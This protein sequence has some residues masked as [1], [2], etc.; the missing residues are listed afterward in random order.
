MILITGGAGFI[1]SNFIYCWQQHC[2][3]EI[4]NIDCLTYAG[5]LYN[6]Q[7]VD[8]NHIFINADIN[9]Y[10]DIKNIIDKFKPR[11]V[12]HFAAESHVD[13][14]ITNPQ[15]FINTNVLGTFNLLHASLQYY[16]QLD[17]SKKSTFKFI[18]ISTDEVYGSL[19]KEDNA[20]TE[21]TNYAPNSP[22]SASKAASDHIARS[23]FHTYGLPCI[24]THCSNNY[25]PY[26]FPEKLIPLVISNALNGKALPIYGDGLNIRDWLHVSDHCQ[27]LIT[28]LNNGQNGEVYNIGGCNEKT[29]LEVVN[30]ICNILDGLQ[31]KTDGLSYKQQITFVQDRL[32]HDRRYAIDNTKI[33]QELNWQ[34][35]Y[36]FEQGIKN[37]VD[38]YLNNQ[39][40]LKKIISGEYKELKSLEK[41]NVNI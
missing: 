38:W 3:E 35:Q 33:Q 27:A 11:A 2:T 6:L 15:S 21:Q 28:I 25:G 19:N 37:T 18:H 4:I 20:F 12:L 41:N 1:G 24:I 29:N 22:Y 39:E 32:G 16:N 23:F 13:R 36:T 9:N 7:H 5:N 8:T 26:Q 31:P 30:T 40:W 17:E 10:T 34:P 14:S